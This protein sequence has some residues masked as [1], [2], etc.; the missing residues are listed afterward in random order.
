VRDTRYL[1]VTKSGISAL[2][3]SW[4]AGLV[5]LY[6]PDRA[7]NFADVVLGFDT[8]AEYL[9]NADLY[10]GCTV[11]RVAN[12]IGSGTF[13]L[14]GETITVARNNGRHHLHGGSRASFDKVEWAAEVAESSDG[15]RVIFRHTSPHLEEGYP[16]RLDVAVTYTL[17]TANELWIQYEARTDRTTPISLTNH[18]YWNLCGAGSPSILNHHL[19][20]AADY[21]T[22]TDDDLIPTGAIAPVTGTALD[23]TRE[24]VVGERIAELEFSG[25]LGYDHNYVLNMRRNEPTFAARLR[26]LRSGRV[27]EISTTQPCMQFYSGNFLTS[28]RGKSGRRY[29][30]RSGLCLE[31]QGFPDAVNHPEFRSVLVGAEDVYR[32]TVVFRLSVDSQTR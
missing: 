22:P 8:P 11:G 32:H 23:F 17:T 3:S 21:Y 12:R 29:I 5:A 20:V 28:I 18:T 26:D 27:V 10:F 9:E 16:G 19:T 31:P 14:A 4:G 2:L 15:P 13:H 25:A 24:H 6:T 30:R 7:G 1:L